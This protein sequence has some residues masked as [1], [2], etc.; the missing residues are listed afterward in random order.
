[1]YL[2][3][4]KQRCPSFYRQIARNGYSTTFV[5]KGTSRIGR[6]VHIVISTCSQYT[7]AL[8]GLGIGATSTDGKCRRQQTWCPPR[9]NFTRVGESNVSHLSLSFIIRSHRPRWS[10]VKVNLGAGCFWVTSPRVTVVS[11]CRASRK[12]R[13]LQ[14]A[15]ASGVRRDKAAL[16]SGCKA[17]PAIRSRRKQSE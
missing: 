10:V 8:C 2:S 15:T 3:C 17:H 7:S 13:R 12:N 11:A 4:G 6:Y 16:S 14:R 5:R 9:P 1:M